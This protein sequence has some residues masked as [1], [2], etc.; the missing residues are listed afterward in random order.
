MFKHSE[1]VEV[2]VSA[3]G[4]IALTFCFAVLAFCL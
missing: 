4:L 1:V 3:I 2:G